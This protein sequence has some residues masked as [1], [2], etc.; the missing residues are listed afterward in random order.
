[1]KICQLFKSRCNAIQDRRRLTK[2]PSR[3]YRLTAA[4]AFLIL[5]AG[6]QK[7][8]LMEQMESLSQNYEREWQ[9]KQSKRT[10][11]ICQLVDES[12]A[13]NFPHLT[14]Y[15]GDYVLGTYSYHYVVAGAAF[16]NGF[17]HK[18]DSI[19]NIFIGSKDSF[20]SHP[21]YFSSDI[22]VFTRTIGRALLVEGKANGIT[23]K[24]DVCTLK[25]TWAMRS[26]TKTLALSYSVNL[27]Q[28]ALK[29]QLDGHKD[30]RLQ[31]LY[32]IQNEAFL[33]KQSKRVLPL[34][35]LS[36]YR[37]P[38]ASLFTKT[39]A[40]IR[41]AHSGGKFGFTMPA[42]KTPKFMVAIYPST[43]SVN[44][45]FF[46]PVMKKQA[47]ASE[48]PSTKAQPSQ[49][50][51]ASPHLATVSTTVRID[52]LR[53]KNTVFYNTP[54]EKVIYYKNAPFAV[55]YG[56]YNQDNALQLPNLGPYQ[57]AITTRNK[58]QRQPLVQGKLNTYSEGRRGRLIYTQM[59]TDKSDFPPTWQTKVTRVSRKGRLIGETRVIPTSL[60]HS[61]V[62]DKGN[63]YISIV[64]E[65]DLPVCQFYLKR[66]GKSK[67]RLNCS[68]LNPPRRNLAAKDKAAPSPKEKWRK[69]S[70]DSLFSLSYDRR[71]FPQQDIAFMDFDQL[72]T[73]NRFRH[74]AP[75][76]L[77][78]GCESPLDSLL[79]LLNKL[80]QINPKVVHLDNCFVD[81]RA[82]SYQVEFYKIAKAK[83]KATPHVAE[84]YSIS[85]N[86]SIYWNILL[87][88]MSGGS[89]EGSKK[90][91]Q[92]PK[93][94]SAMSEKDA[95][96]TTDIVLYLQATAKGNTIYFQAKTKDPKTR[97]KSIKLY[98]NDRI[99]ES[100]NSSIFKLT[101]PLNEAQLQNELILRA[102]SVSARVTDF[103][104]HHKIS[105]SEYSYFISK[106][107]QLKIAK[108]G[109]NLVLKP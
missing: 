79:P 86:K 47:K 10:D 108:K 33:A 5:V 27:N 17:N 29:I 34:G 80:E 12:L 7:D 19:K 41:L 82:V 53:Y 76:P 31:Y 95:P 104:Y 2:A 103:Q 107:F 32:K 93:L 44:T 69:V 87:S 97:H 109:G 24:G 11:Y 49:R 102:T 45:G 66:Y 98:V 4:L 9:K 15:L 56:R 36:S 92:R 40:T 68:S 18:Y 100:K 25:T 55:L 14:P 26:S 83:A 20:R 48:T 50:L 89:T 59:A 46:E 13:K 54:F 52:N 63:F 72:S 42:S 78:L 74:Q 38:T 94:S 8:R 106:P 51:T 73:V 37:H 61:F 88:E 30:L 58:P 1:M 105:S 64:D 43:D 101:L 3:G 71:K 57:L 60:N 35:R 81:P 77:E 91:Q 99:F 6:C 39:P 90:E 65:Y 21:A 22:K 28:N 85:Q 75:L 67:V 70:K 23:L 62:L 84:R 96:A 16:S